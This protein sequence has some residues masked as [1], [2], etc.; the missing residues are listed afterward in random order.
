[1]IGLPLIPYLYAVEQPDEIPLFVDPKM[2]GFL[3]D[4]YRRQHLKSVAPDLANGLTP[5]GN[6]YE[7]VGTAYDRTVY[8]YQIETSSA[9]DLAF[10]KKYSSSPNRSH[11]RTV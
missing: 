4:Q 6:W 2:V 11:F 1:M 10:I 3:R 5:G 8:A 9:Q 7:L